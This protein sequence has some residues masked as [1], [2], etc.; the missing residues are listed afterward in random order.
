VSDSKSWAQIKEGFGIEEIPAELYG[1]GAMTC[2]HCGPEFKNMKLYTTKS[3]VSDGTAA[4][5]R[6]VI[7]AVRLDAMCKTHAMWLYGEDD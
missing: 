7:D 2:V 3:I 6:R 5:H 4:G 1:N